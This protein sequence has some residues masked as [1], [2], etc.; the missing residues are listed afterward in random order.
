MIARVFS[1]RQN[2]IFKAVDKTNVSWYNSYQKKGKD[3]ISYEQIYRSHAGLDP[4]RRFGAGYYCHTVGHA[5]G[6]ITDIFP[7][8]YG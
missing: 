5:A 1:F 8:Y 4:L 3:S 7:G 2:N 6:I